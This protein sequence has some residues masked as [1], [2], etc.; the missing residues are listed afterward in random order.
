MDD[1]EF[2]QVEERSNMPKVLLVED[3]E[4]L[5]ATWSALLQRDGIDVVW[6]KSLTGAKGLFDMHP[7]T[8][9]MVV[10]ACVDGR[11]PDSM[12]FIIYARSRGFDRPII[13]KSSD[14]PRRLPLLAAG[15]SH[16]AE[17]NELIPLVHKLL[18]AN[19]SQ[20]PVH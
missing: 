17:L 11:D 14:P 3:H 9:L 20:P 5:G 19:G 4:D 16:E 6:A 18:K 10:D 15:A 8:D 1:D 12:P 13:A 2:F 7:D